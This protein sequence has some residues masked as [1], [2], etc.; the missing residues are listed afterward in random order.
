M[1]DRRY[2]SC[3]TQG[4][5][6]SVARKPRAVVVGNSVFAANAA[7]QFRLLG[8]EVCTIG[9]CEDVARVVL[10]KKPSAVLLPAETAIESGHLIAA[11]MRR[12][13]PRLKIVLVGEVHTPAAERFARF[14]GATYAVESDGAGKVVATLVA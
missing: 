11:K 13:R 6:A 4:G 8:W 5:A 10:S 3:G 12:I 7:D 14:V 2:F 1:N 9:N